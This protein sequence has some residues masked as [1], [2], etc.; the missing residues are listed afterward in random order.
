MRYTIMMA[1]FFDDD[2]THK[3]KK[4]K[5][6]WSTA[7]GKTV[8]HPLFSVSLPVLLKSYICRLIKSISVVSY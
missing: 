8:N 6:N 1:K 7:N 4:R 2:Q 3:G 5:A